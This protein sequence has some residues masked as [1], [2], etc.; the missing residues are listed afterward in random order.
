MSPDGPNFEAVFRK[1]EALNGNNPESLQTIIRYLRFFKGTD[2]YG[3]YIKHYL[4]MLPADVAK[5]FAEPKVVKVEVKAVE[6][7]VV[8]T[9]AKPPKRGRPAKK[10]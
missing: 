4:P 1:M 10:A 6:V 7:P 2:E 8:T 3:L 9:K 5:E